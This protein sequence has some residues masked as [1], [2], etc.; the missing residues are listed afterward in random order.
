MSQSQ[1]KAFITGKPE[2]VC[3]CYLYAHIYTNLAVFLA[4][5][6]IKK[7]IIIALELVL[8]KIAKVGALAG[9]VG[10]ACSS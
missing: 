3:S 10:R 7:E 2:P 4:T 9:S 1:R 6:C 8:I 5:L